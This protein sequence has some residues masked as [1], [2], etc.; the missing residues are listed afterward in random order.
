MTII[1]ISSL[2]TQQLTMSIQ[3]PSMDTYNRLHAVH[4]D[5]IKCPCST[6]SIAYNR[7]IELSATFHKICSSDFISEG[8][9]SILKYSEMKYIPPDWRNHAYS[10]FRL[11]ADLCRLA[12]Q[13]MHDTV[14]RFLLQLFITSNAMYEGD[15]EQQ[16]NVTIDQLFH[17][18]ALAFSQFV[19][20]MHLFIQIDQPFHLA[21]TTSSASP[22]NL[23]QTPT[24]NGNDLQFSSSDQ[25]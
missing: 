15:F 14:K 8:W 20:S 2:S 7:F 1:C 18:I 22:V 6:I 10:Q 25:V 4:P 23:I 21:E 13:T 16:L 19:E 24:S 5:T 9:L 3:N 12:N 17:S 11:L